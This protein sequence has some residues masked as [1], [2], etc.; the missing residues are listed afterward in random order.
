[1][2]KKAKGRTRGVGVV[3]GGVLPT[4]EVHDGIADFLDPRPMEEAFAL[5]GDDTRDNALLGIII[6]SDSIGH[7]LGVALLE[8]GTPDGVAVGVDN[9]LGIEHLGVE[10]DPDFVGF[11]LHGF[12]FYLALV[13][14]LCLASVDIE[15]DG[16]LSLIVD[17][18]G[19]GTRRVAYD[20]QLG[21]ERIG[22]KAERIV[23][24]G[25]KRIDQR[26]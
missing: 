5:L 7:I 19:E 1:M 20:G 24:H 3:A 14:E 12:I 9:M 11:E 15:G 26:F 6:E 2:G 17:Y 13:V 22:G 8:E 18:A 10:V 25:V 21:V 4:I 23:V 16:V